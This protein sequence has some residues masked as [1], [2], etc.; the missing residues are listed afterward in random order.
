ML[1]LNKFKKNY[2]RKTEISSPSPPVYILDSISLFF[3]KGGKYHQIVYFFI[4]ASPTC[5]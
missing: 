4:S 1:K 2:Y 3:S 5:L